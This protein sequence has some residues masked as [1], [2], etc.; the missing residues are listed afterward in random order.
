MWEGQSVLWITVTLIGHEEIHIYVDHLVDEPEEIAVEDIEPLELVQLGEEPTVDQ[1][2]DAIQVDDSVDYND[3]DS[4]YKDEVDSEGDA[5]DHYYDPIK[6]DA[7]EF[8]YRRAGKE[9]VIEEQHE[10]LVNDVVEDS[11]ESGG[12]DLEEEP[13]L[14]HHTGR[15]FDDDNS[16]SWDNKKDVHDEPV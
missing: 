9:L 1:A 15:S 13:D 4:Y 11:T 12:S 16:D 2:L 6:V 3:H 5:S 8:Y 7:T 14:L 10:D